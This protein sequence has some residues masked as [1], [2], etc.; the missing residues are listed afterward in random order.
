VIVAYF[1]DTSIAVC[2]YQ[3]SARVLDVL[4]RHHDSVVISTLCLVELRRGIYR[5]SAYVA[6]V[7]ARLDILLAGIPV[8]DFDQAAVDAY[9]AIVAQLGFSGGCDFDRM[10][11][12]HA[13]SVGATLVTANTSDFAGI[14]GLQLENWTLP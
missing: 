8:L 3:G 4:G 5:R 10:I 12:A 2:A 14:S 6:Q 7:R 13:L 1:L 9:D 11:A